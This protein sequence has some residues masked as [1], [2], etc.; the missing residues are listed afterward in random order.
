MADAFV[1]AAIIG[2]G[3]CGAYGETVRNGA[4]MTILVLLPVV[5][6]PATTSAETIAAATC[7]RG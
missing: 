5:M 3:G 4:R 6:A 2:T 1:F 7:K